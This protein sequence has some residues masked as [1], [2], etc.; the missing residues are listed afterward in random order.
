MVDFN[1]RYTAIVK[2]FDSNKAFGFA[3]CEEVDDDVFLHKSNMRNM[4]IPRDAD[5]IN[6]I[7]EK[8]DRGYTGKDIMLGDIGEGNEEF[9]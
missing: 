1:K 6:F 4:V 3:Y 7:L 8:G 2:F 9:E 5:K